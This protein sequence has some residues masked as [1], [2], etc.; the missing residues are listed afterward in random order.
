MRPARPRSCPGP[1]GFLALFVAV[2]TAAALPGCDR[3]QAGSGAEA[4]REALP[5]G[6]SLVRYAALPAEPT[7]T[8]EPDLSIGVLE[9][10]AWEMFGDVRGIDADADGNIHILD[11]QTRDI[12]VFDAE[13]GYLRTL[14][15]P[16]EGPGEISAA[17]GIQFDPDGRLWV[18]DHGKMHLLVL[19]ADGTELERVPFPVRSFGFV[20]EGAMDR[21]GRLWHAFTERAGPASMPEDG[22]NEST[23]RRWMTS[24]DPGSGTADSVFVGEQASRS[25]RIRMGN[26]F[27]VRGIPHSPS[28]FLRMDPL[29]GFWRGDGSGDYRVAR[30]DG[31]GDTVVVVDVALDRIPVTASD[32]DRFIGQ[33]TGQDP[34]LE[35]PA[36]ELAGLMP[37]RKPAVDQAFADLEGRLWVRRV[38]DPDAR[39]LYDLFDREGEH[40]ITLELGFEPMAYW[41]P[42]IRD[43]NAYFLV[44]GELGV[45]S[46]VR[47]PLGDLPA[48]GPA[49]D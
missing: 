9:G 30:L 49:S 32:R 38:A 12:R 13:G 10:E 36:R 48:R 29:G 35:R 7:V 16:G 24:F 3:A 39:P 4:T 42:T 46:V 43:G 6:G 28:S 34:D 31:A 41:V 44:A 8:L 1:V 14:G 22:L 37:A 47:V 11:F 25:F 33:M 40:L 27:M 17:N 19:A 15:G 5:N 18:N 2:A 45:A 20:W 26:G 23:A 21:E